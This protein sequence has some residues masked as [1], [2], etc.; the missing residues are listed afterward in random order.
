MTPSIA[1][2]T[3]GAVPHVSA[4][5]PAAKAKAA[6]DWEWYHRCL[7]TVGEVRYFGFRDLNGVAG[8]DVVLVHEGL[9]M[10]ALEWTMSTL[11]RIR[12]ANGKLVWVEPHQRTTFAASVFEP[13]FFDVV[14]L[15]VKYQ[16]M[17]Y[18]ALVAGLRSPQSDLAPWSLFGHSSLADFYGDPRRFAVPTSPETVARHLD[19][20]LSPHYGERIA[21]MMR[22]FTFPSPDSWYGDSAARQPNIL[23]EAEVAIAEDEAGPASVRAVIAGLLAQ[24]GLGVTLRRS[25]VRAAATA[26]AYVAMG[27]VHL[28]GGAADVLRFD[29]V[30][31]LPED[32]RYVIWDDVFVAGESYLPLHGVGPLMRQGGRV[33]DA[34]AARASA[35]RVAGELGDPSV[36]ERILAGQRRAHTL[37]TDP[38][39]VAGKLGIPASRPQPAP[40]P[41]RPPGTT[42]RRPA[43]PV[44]IGAV[45]SDEISVVIQGAIGSDELPEQVVDSVRRHLPGAEVIISTWAGARELQADADVRVESVDPGA[46]WQVHEEW[47]SNTNRLLVST[48]AGLRA[49]RRPYTLKLRTDTPVSGT[50]FLKLF[51]AYPE[52]G[53]ALRL[54]RERMVVIN[55][56]CWNPETSPF[57]LFG[58][59]DT[60]NFGRTDDLL[61]VWDRPLDDE[62]ANTTWFLTH[63]RPDPEHALLPAFRYAPEQLLWLGF[64]RKHLA[65]PFAHFL[66]DNPVARLLAQLSAANNL[67]IAEPERF[68]VTLPKFAGRAAL[69]PDALVTHAM[70]QT[71][72]ERFCLNSPNG[73][74][75]AVVAELE[76]GDAPATPATPA[77]PA[78]DAAHR[79]RLSAMAERAMAETVHPLHGARE[80]VVLADA[81]ELLACED[82]LRTYADEMSGSPLATLAIDASRLPQDTAE[83]QIRDLV[84]RCGLDQREDV[85]LLAVVGQRDLAQRRRMLRGVRALYGRHG[86]DASPVAV[87]TPA[88]I[89]DLR[90]RADA[91]ARD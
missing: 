67:V 4:L 45:A 51:G 28:D 53:S 50:G 58:V 48:L 85:D 68:G 6:S 5:L 32:P 86:E 15:V 73:A 7:S 64:L 41:A 44:R 72:H 33:I 13:D 60:V 17:E 57:G 47:P 38:V 49:S 23:K 42:A 69:A 46:P 12:G 66:D 81:E 16:L 76:R 14:D 90:A 19:C 27:P 3:P 30:A 20:D 9:E 74:V 54:L 77:T 84:I 36:R 35:A 11:A 39:F 52:R 79:E 8:F 55:Y 88:S 26:E 89:T 21:P 78:I 31:V 70:W 2:V 29:T 56:Y 80:F 87:Y 22:L 62:P 91:A 10:A 71:L 18:P 63:S 59:A 37:L 83:R 43:A 65:V 24:C 82:L 25:R 34:T 40:A 61:A 75:E 1:V